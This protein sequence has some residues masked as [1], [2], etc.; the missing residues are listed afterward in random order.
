MRHIEE[1]QI[2]EWAA[3]YH[4][5]GKFSP[6]EV[7]ALE[8]WLA[9]DPANVER[10]SAFR[11]QYCEL[12]QLAFTEVVDE[13]R[14]WQ[15]V[16]Q[17]IRKPV[18]RLVPQWAYYAASVLLL[19]AASL[20]WLQYQQ[21]N[22][23]VPQTGFDQLAEIGSPKATLILG[24]GSEVNLTD[25]Q[26]QSFS[27]SDGTEIRKDEKNNLSYTGAAESGELIYNTISVPRAGEFSL[28]LADG[29]KV[30][31]NAD[32]QLRYPVRF[33]AQ[34]REVF[35]IGEAYFEVSHRDDQPF[36]VHVND[37]KVRVLGT[38]FNVSGYASQA[39]IATTLVEGS[40]Q[41]GY[42]TDDVL[43]R[44][45]QQ[46]VVSKGVDGI[47]VQEVDASIYTSWINGVFEFENA[48]LQYLCNQLAR[49]YNVDFFF[50]QPDLKEIRFTGAFKRD[51]SI[52]YAIGLIEQLTKVNF[53]VEGNQIIIEK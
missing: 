34:T 43:L 40:V 28:S 33:G 46:S 24:D 10:F 35:L 19:L 21:Q 47:A 31:L 14:A 32:S 15:K 41:V 27:E 17:A 50:T 1:E 18:R 23:P 2:I 51:Q 3:K 22:D 29:T 26:E 13:D 49:W 38:K 30:W 48:D 9:E 45:G 37:T 12:R 16:Q 44:P 11:K 5:G 20:F 39:F 53:R 4:G 8:N 25:Q 6:Q 52:N 42:L 36:V 7:E